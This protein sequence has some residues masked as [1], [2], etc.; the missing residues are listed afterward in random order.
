MGDGFL[1]AAQI[2]GLQEH[3][4]EMK[5]AYRKT[6]PYGEEPTEENLTNW[7]V[8]GAGGS[9]TDIDG[10]A[11]SSNRK[12]TMYWFS[13][14]IESQVGAGGFAVGNKLSLADVL[15]YNAF[16]ETLEEHQVGTCSIV[17]PVLY[18]LQSSTLLHSLRRTRQI[19]FRLRFRIRSVAR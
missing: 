6:C 19:R 15:I 17:I 9:A 8:K 18:L 14:R 3:L 2:L 4:S 1:E 16:A 5:Q 10:N 12:R 13:Q 7:F 11:D